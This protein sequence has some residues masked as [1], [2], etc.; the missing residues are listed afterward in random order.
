M[1]FSNTFVTLNDVSIT[2]LNDVAGQVIVVSSD[3]LNLT[4]L[5]NTQLTGYTGSQGTQGNVG[6]S[7]STGANGNAGFTG[8]IGIGFTGSQGGTGFTGSQGDQGNA[9]YALSLIHI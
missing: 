8:S 5:S 3:G 1:A 2:D 4:A 9:G 7:G 6:F